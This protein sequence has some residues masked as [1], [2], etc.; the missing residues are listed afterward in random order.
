M[1]PQRKVSMCD[2]GC[3]VSASVFLSLPVLCLW[4]CSSSWGSLHWRWWSHTACSHRTDHCY[5][6]Q[7]GSPCSP[8][9]LTSKAKKNMQMKQ[10]V[11]HIKVPFKNRCLN[12]LRRCVFLE[13]LFEMAEMVFKVKTTLNADGVLWF[14]PHNLPLARWLH[15]KWWFIKANEAF[16]SGVRS[17][18][19]IQQ[20][21]SASPREAYYALFTRQ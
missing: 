4:R 7:G 17:N 12:V 16:L 1:F 3:I 11:D 19:F 18:S 13:M 9:S 6:W 20:H 8:A 5:C 15:P 10:F 14:M 21:S 2:C